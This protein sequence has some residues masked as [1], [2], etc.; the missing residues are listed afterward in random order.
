MHQVLM[1]RSVIVPI[2]TRICAPGR[3]IRRSSS[4]SGATSQRGVADS[5][6]GQ[7]WSCPVVQLW[8]PSQNSV[9]PF[10]GV[11]SARE[12]GRRRAGRG[13]CGRTRTKNVSFE[14]S[15]EEIRQGENGPESA[16]FVLSMPG[17]FGCSLQSERREDSGRRSDLVRESAR[18]GMRAH[19]G[20][21]LCTFCRCV[22]PAIA[23]LAVKRLSLMPGPR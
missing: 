12:R 23:Q 3:T 21:S 8:L 22:A 5:R 16:R 14:S 19:Q 6:V 17:Q 10:S 4:V 20:A 9:E 1:S 13:A 11:K 18:G 7:T 2:G 15:V